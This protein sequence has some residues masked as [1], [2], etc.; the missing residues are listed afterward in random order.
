MSLD[1]QDF[2]LFLC[3][4]G[5]PVATEFNVAQSDNI[6]CLRFI[7]QSERSQIKSTTTYKKAIVTESMD[8]LIYVCRVQDMFLSYLCLLKKIAHYQ[9]YIIRQKRLACENHRTL[10]PTASS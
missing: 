2:H 5:F 1:C 3:L 7:A 10:G 9:D 8:A 4:S 6:H